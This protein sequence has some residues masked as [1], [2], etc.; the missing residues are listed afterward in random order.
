MRRNAKDDTDLAGK[1]PDRWGKGAASAD[2]TSSSPP[3]EAEP[4][5][6]RLLTD[7]VCGTSVLDKVRGVK[8]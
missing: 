8:P 7:S 5:V 2:H 1:D 3:A 6:R 4:A